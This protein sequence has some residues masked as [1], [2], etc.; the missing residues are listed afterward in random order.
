M[1]FASKGALVNILIIINMDIITVIISNLIKL[2][3]YG[4]HCGHLQVITS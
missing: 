1:A 4:K 2:I 3:E